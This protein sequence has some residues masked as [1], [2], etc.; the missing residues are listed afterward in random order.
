MAEGGR[1]MG[2]ATVSQR[3]LKV[4]TF[5][6]LRL[7]TTSGPAKGYFAAHLIVTSTRRDIGL[8]SGEIPA[9]TNL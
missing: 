2:R 1:F 4:L 9:G 6:P 7:I 3:L 5:R 8:F